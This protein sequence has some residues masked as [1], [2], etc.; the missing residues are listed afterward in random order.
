MKKMTVNW[1][2]VVSLAVLPTVIAVP[3]LSASALTTAKDKG[4]EVVKP[5]LCEPYP[6]CVIYQ[7][8]RSTDEM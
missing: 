2:R 3:L 6:E 8:Q 7:Q 1:K 4:D 5:M